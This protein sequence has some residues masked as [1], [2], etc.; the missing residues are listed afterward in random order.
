[1]LL[2]TFHAWFAFSFFAADRLLVNRALLV[3]GKVF[4]LPD[5]DLS[6]LGDGVHGV[7]FYL[8]GGSLV[9]WVAKPNVSDDFKALLGLDPTYS[10]GTFGGET[11]RTARRTAGPTRRRRT[12]AALPFGTRQCGAR[13][14]W[15]NVCGIKGKI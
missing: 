4:R 13:V 1:M 12:R 9:G 3:V 5:A 7:S 8:F 15:Q 14:S 10:T 6:D 2:Q 11:R